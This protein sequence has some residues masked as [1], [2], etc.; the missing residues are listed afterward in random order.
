[1]Q[2]LRCP[3]RKWAVMSF[4]PINGLCCFRDREMLPSL[5]STCWLQEQI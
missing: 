4:N 3:T 5:L 1:M 2:W